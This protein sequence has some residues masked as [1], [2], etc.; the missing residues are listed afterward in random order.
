MRRKIASRDVGIGRSRL[1][2]VSWRIASSTAGMISPAREGM[3]TELSNIVPATRFVNVDIEVNLALEGLELLVEAALAE[4]Q[5]LG[6]TVNVVVIPQS[7]HTDQVV[8][9]A[10]SAGTTVQQG[11]RVTIY[12]TQP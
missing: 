12:V 4:L 1:A 6:L 7:P 9:T 3:R 5:A 2:D 11:D 8:L 10:P